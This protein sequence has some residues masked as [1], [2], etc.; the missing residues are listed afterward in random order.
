MGELQHPQ[1]GTQS[2]KP[3]VHLSD[4]HFTASGGGLA[5]RNKSL[6]VDVLN[7]LKVMTDQLGSAE[8]VFVTGD[9]AFSGL[10]AEYALAREWLDKVTTVV[11]AARTSV[12]CVPG[13]HDVHR[14]AIGPTG[15]SIRDTLRASICQTLLHT[16]AARWPSFRSLFHFLN[17]PSYSTPFINLTTE[18]RGLNS[19]TPKREKGWP[20][21]SGHNSGR[22]YVGISRS[23]PAPWSHE[24]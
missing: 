17:W 24:A 18:W 20:Y 6:R 10:P 8:A 11:G 15:E 13:N 22:C 5:R 2:L 23:A 19:L 7:D 3:I 9:I 16:A 21:K 1:E 4:I 12:L 14:P